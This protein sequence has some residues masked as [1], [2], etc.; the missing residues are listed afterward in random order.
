LNFLED[1][2][3]TRCTISSGNSIYCFHNSKKCT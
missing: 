2:G 1:M 3:E